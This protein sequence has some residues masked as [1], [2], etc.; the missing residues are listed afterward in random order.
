MQSRK[1]IIEHSKQSQ[2]VAVFKMLS[3]SLLF[4]YLFIYQRFQ[5]LIM[6]RLLAGW[7]SE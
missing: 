6:Q 4:I 7:V 2:S 1:Q 5:Y 3:V